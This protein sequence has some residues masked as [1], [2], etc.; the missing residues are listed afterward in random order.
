MKFMMISILVSLFTI[1]CNSED[2]KVSEPAAVTVTDLEGTS[3]GR[4][5]SRCYVEDDVEYKD[6][7]SFGVHEGGGTY[8]F[9]SIDYDLNEDN[10]YTNC[11]DNYEFSSRRWDGTYTVSKNT[12]T[13]SAQD[14]R[15]EALSAGAIT[16]FEDIELCGYNEWTIST[17]R[18]VTGVSCLGEVMS[19]YTASGSITYHTSYVR[20][21]G[22]NHELVQ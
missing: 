12:L 7:W 21:E 20:I 10:E 9:E 15:I 3:G 13:I 6:T 19:G 17:Q 4:T 14:I 2:T 1:S 11:D 22:E 18:V 16:L 5:W 8:R